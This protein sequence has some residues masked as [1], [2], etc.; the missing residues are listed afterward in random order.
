MHDIHTHLYWDS[1]DVD[2]DAVIARA[3][4]AG[5]DDMFVIGC[6]VDESRQCIA[7]TEQYSEIFASIGIHPHEFQSMD[8]VQNLASDIEAL[9]ALARESKKVIAVGECGLDYYVR[10][11]V[12]DPQQSFIGR[13]AVT[14]SEETKVVQ[15]QGFL[16][17]IELARDL[18]L[19]LI[20][21]CRDAY[22]D[23]LGILRADAADISACILHCYMGDTE[24]TKQFLTLPNVYFSFTANI[25]YPVK[26]ALVGTKD[27]LTETVKLVPLE[28][29]FAETDC[30]F[31]APQSKRGERNEPAY[32]AQTIEEIARLQG[33]DRDM[34]IQ[35]IDENVHEVFR[36]SVDQL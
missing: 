2:R 27:D 18:R 13:G 30:P 19:P 6:T 10:P 25:T 21:H 7:L 15:R 31:L 9:R 24:V 26:K 32:V 33:L 34:F 14:V 16:A 28:R 4:A 5:I 17:Q 8:D 12:M 23:M 36:N 35:Q 22:E 11:A 3:H 20:I 29:L 1:Y